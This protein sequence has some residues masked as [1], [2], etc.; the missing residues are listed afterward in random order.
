MTRN[1]LIVGIT[2]S[3]KS[4]L[5]NVLTNTNQFEERNSGISVTK[6]FQKSD[7]FE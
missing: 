1:I 3:G 4:A 2:G 6:N 7:P 5:A